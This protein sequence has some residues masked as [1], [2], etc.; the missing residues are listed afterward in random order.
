MGYVGVKP[1]AVPLTSADITDGIITSAKIADGTIVNADINASAAIASTKLSGVASGILQ[2]K[3][4]TYTSTQT[5]SNNE[6][7]SEVTGMNLSITPT[8]ASSKILVNMVIHGGSSNWAI[9]RLY[10]GG[11]A[12]SGAKP[13]DVSNR[14]GASTAGMY[15]DN[16]N[17]A[18]PF[19]INYLD[20]PATTSS[21]TYSLYVLNYASGNSFYLNRST[22]DNDYS[23]VG[24]YISTITL[25]EISSTV[26]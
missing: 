13:A 7:W 3:H 15:R 5:I 26:L 21:T 2:V 11:S 19:I 23:A 9:G 24:R 25:M 10:R 4:L 14:L 17:Q 20:D 8:S 22:G 16:E 1:S 18:R 12:I 6:T